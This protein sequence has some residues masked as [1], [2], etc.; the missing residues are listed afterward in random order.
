MNN[1]RKMK[2]KENSNVK[3]AIETANNIINHYKFLGDALN[4]F[5]NEFTITS[6][7][8][9]MHM[10]NEVKRVSD[11]I[12]RDECHEFKSYCFEKGIKINK[13]NKLELMNNFLYERF[14]VEIDKKEI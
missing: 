4:K 2:L 9:K 5:A 6:H 8:A 12:N 3:E 14:G 1:D 13:I 10:I 11:A 7:L